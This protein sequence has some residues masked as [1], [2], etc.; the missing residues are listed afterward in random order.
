MKNLVLAFL[1]TFFASIGLSPARAQSPTPFAELLS[2]KKY[3]QTLKFKDIPAEGW[4][5]FSLVGEDSISIQVM[6]ALQSIGNILGYYLTKGETISSEGV[7]YLIA[8]RGNISGLSKAVQGVGFA[9]DKTSDE[10]GVTPEM[11]LELALI[12][13]QKATA[14]TQ[15]QPFDPKTVL[16]KPKPVTDTSQDRLKQIGL[17]VMMYSQDY[18][19]VLPPM[20]DVKKFQ[21]VVMPYIKNLATFINPA[22]S[23]PYVP[24][25][26]L[27]EHKLATIPEP[28]SFV[29]I[30]EDSPAADG[31]R[32]VV[33]VDGHTKRVSEAE[34]QRLKRASKIP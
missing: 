10:L 32:G 2:G 19:E 31:T 21:D 28:A 3:P 17:A 30:Y 6:L 4:V 25:A 16:P 27:S 11:S 26:I 13:L 33:F 5:R 8:Y 20:K 12:N 23:K 7:T 9:G 1:L 29:L 34:W 24:N 18:D 22:T 14:I 15:I